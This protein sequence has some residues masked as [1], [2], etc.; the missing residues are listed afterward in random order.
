VGRTPEEK[1]MVM[2]L[3]ARNRAPK[4]HP[5]REELPAHLPRQEVIIRCAEANC[6]CRQCG[7]QKKLSGYEQSEE[8][9]VEPARFFV[10]VIKRE[11]RA[12]AR[13]EEA[14]VSRAAAA[15]DYRERQS[16]R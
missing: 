13:C 7:E 4:P 6:H 11:K 15:E 3:F 2:R 16:R 14:G 12:C 9:D 10:R 5:G 8:L 1:Q